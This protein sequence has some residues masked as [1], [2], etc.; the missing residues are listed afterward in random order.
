L[1]IRVPLT[2]VENI[3]PDR[4]ALVVLERLWAPFQDLD[5]A[6][7][8]IPLPA[9]CWANLARSGALH[10]FGSRREVLWHLGR[11]EKLAGKRKGAKQLTLDEPI[12][13]ALEME[14][15]RDWVPLLTLSA[16]ETVSWDFATQSMTTGNHPIAFRRGELAPYGA[17]TV[18]ELETR[19]IGDTVRVA[20]SVISRQAPPTARGMIFIIL[21]DESGR[22][23]TAITP[24]VSAQLG[25][26]LRAPALL[27]E[28]VLEGTPE[29]KL[30]KKTGRYR[31]V[32]IKK[33]W[34]VD[35]VLGR[36]ERLH[37]A[38]GHPGE[39]PRA[40]VARQAQA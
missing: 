23:P 24:D 28:G 13:Q 32:L 38:A 20:G 18:A 3:S 8:R 16:E 35:Q 22:I 33:L 40:G 14:L 21:E 5:E 15:P 34:P 19:R 11:L 39:H 27:V 9:D 1:A 25:A 10:M 37:G 12:Q 6:Y 17:L 30:G 7:R 26:S 29:E 4:A 2:A 31:S 36:R